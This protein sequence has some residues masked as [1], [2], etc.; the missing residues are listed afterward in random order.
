MGVYSVQALDE[1][2]YYK[3]SFTEAGQS[4]CASYSPGCGYLNAR[5]EQWMD[6]FKQAKSGDE[7]LQAILRR[8]V[9]MLEARRD[10][11]RFA[12]MLREEMVCNIFLFVVACR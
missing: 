8:Y 3:G 2:D 4:K 10:K 12:G 7:R 1:P 9:N 11:D 6:I 5:T